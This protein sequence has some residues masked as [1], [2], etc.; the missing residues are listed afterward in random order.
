M[1]RGPKRERPDPIPGTITKRSVQVKDPNRVSVYVDG[2][3]SFGMHLEAAVDLG[4][5][6]GV[7]L[8]EELL[9]HCLQADEAYR[10]RRKAL[11]LLAHR[12]RSV[13]ELEQR[14]G[15]AGFGP[16]AI[17]N[18]VERMDRLGY[19][20]DLAFATSLARDRLLSGKLGQR[21]V[22]DDLRRKGVDPTLA[23]RVVAEVSLGRDETEDAYALARKRARAVSD[24]DQARKQQRRLYGL[25][26]RRGFGAEAI[27]AALG[28]IGE[29]IGT[30]DT[31]DQ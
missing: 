28:R 21:R 19:L 20:N 5:Q 31:D 26:A 7:E 24:V 6:K 22:L 14:L 2:A 30:E 11:N 8:S 17:A 13:G 12:Q 23:M 25:L 18:A 9:E 27:R 10:A 3:F 16:A 4:I 15:M 1:R 29:E